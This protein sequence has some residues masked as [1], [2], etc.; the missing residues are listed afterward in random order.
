MKSG[1]LKAWFQAS[2]APFFIATLI[3]LSLGG[4]AAGLVGHWNTVQWLV[5]LFASF[6]VHLATN[7]ADDYFELDTGADSGD[8]IGGSRVVQEGK[9]SPRQL[10]Y[11]LFLLYTLALVCGLWLLWS[12]RIWWLIP[13]MLFSFFSSLFYVGPPIRYG[14][15]GLGELLVGINMGPVMVAGTYWVLTGHLTWEILLFSVPIALMV[16]LIL[17]YQSL[18]D[19]EVDKSVGKITLA[20]R[21]SRNGCLLIYRLFI[22]CTLASILALIDLKMLHPLGLLSLGTMFI[23]YKVDRM[24]AKTDD[25]VELHDRGGKIRLFYILNGLILVLVKGLM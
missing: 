6:F 1:T 9:I 5:V 17:Y 18:P 24:I 13:V 14:Y 7:L 2:R 4:V 23:A 25:W 12:T 3:P 11:A 16:A 22:G 19:I 15:H 10:V 21:F 20:A 8:S